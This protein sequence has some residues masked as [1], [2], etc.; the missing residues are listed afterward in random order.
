MRGQP[1]CET[2]SPP[3]GVWRL[4]PGPHWMLESMAAHGSSVWAIGVGRAGATTSTPSRA[5]MASMKQQW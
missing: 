4:F 2:S 3:P 5:A 1:A